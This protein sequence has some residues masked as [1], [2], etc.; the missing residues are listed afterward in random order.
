MARKVQLPA[1]LRELP[2]RKGAARILG[3]LVRA[4]FAHEEDTRAG[5]PEAGVHDMRVATKRLREALRLSLP[6]FRKKDARK[7]LAW[8]EEI[9]DALGEVREIDVLVKKLSKRAAALGE[10]A[11]MA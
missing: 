3:P 5:D 10:P 1:A 8:V 7:H 2:F 6:A 4:V 9:N 11:G